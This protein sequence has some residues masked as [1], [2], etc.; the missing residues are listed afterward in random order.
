[1]NEM[2]REARWEARYA[3][4]GDYIFG[5]APN[6][7]LAAHASLIDPGAKVL[8]VGDGEGRNSVFLAERGAD[9]HAVEVSPTAISRARRLA[10]ARGVTVHFEQADLLNWIWPESH[11]DA[12]AAIFV[13]FI[14][15]AERPAF[16]AN[17]VRTLRP[18]GILLLEGY[19]PEQIPNRTGGPSD[20]AHCYTETLLRDAFAGMEI[21]RLESYDAL[22]DEGAGHSGMS[23][24]IDLVA[25]K[26]LNPSA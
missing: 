1:M 15:P 26:P 6:A 4:A 8:S 18:G 24:L 11:H 20:P 22:L 10:A 23:A 16:F 7:F 19:R 13:Q 25:R 17:L 12:V 9:V 21:E 3:A 2:T 5:T 14:T